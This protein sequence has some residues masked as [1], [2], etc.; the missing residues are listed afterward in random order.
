M[1]FR[2][3]YRFTDSYPAISHGE[4]VYLSGSCFSENFTCLLSQYGFPVLSNSHGIIYN[5]ISLL[6][7]LEDT[8]SGK[9]YT[10]DDLLQTGGRWIS[11]RHHGQFSHA[12]PGIVLEEINRNILRHR[13]FLQS[14]RHLFITFG[15]AWIYTH[16]VSGDTV[17]N[18]HKLPSSEFEKNL[19][20]VHDIVEKWVTF[21]DRLKN[22]NK[23]L[24]ACF[25][26]SPVKHLRDG[27][28]ENQLSKS[29][30][31]LA[32]NEIN[33]RTGTTYFPAYELVT[34]DLRDYRFYEKDL[35][36][37]NSLAIEYVW[38]RFAEVFFRSGT[39]TVMEQVN[40]YRQLE[41]HRPLKE[42]EAEKHHEKVRQARESLLEKYPYLLL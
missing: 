9:V 18:C 33:R 10:K 40:R 36:H 24:N 30:L 23:N 39:R 2:S 38:E 3:E 27:I 17:A 8:V 34:D 7:S 12:D 31:L 5:P 11:L 41:G 14:A 1:K 16:Q 22:Y 15:T 25:T 21:L 35:A 29:T 37:P 6:D 4:G 26:V 32:I 19:V 13:Q 42:E 20:P 28:H